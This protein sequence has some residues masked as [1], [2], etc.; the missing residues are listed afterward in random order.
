MAIAS[1]IYTVVPDILVADSMHILTKRRPDQKTVCLQ[2]RP[3][4]VS[5]LT[6]SNYPF[7]ILARE[8]VSLCSQKYGTSVK[9]SAVSRSFNEKEKQISGL[10]SALPASTSDSHITSQYHPHVLIARALTATSNHPAA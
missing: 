4:Q 8:T 10:H 5:H 2:E 7:C 9:C 3:D 6:L 1:A